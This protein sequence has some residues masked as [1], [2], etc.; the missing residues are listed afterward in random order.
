MHS[1]HETA[2]AL[3]SYQLEEHKEDQY[4]RLL[5]TWRGL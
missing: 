4:R 3:N 1:W 5:H 2:E